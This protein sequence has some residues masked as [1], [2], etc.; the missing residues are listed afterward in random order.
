M[1]AVMRRSESRIFLYRR[2][3]LPEEETTAPGLQKPAFREP[4]LSG[5][6]GPDIAQ[7]MYGRRPKNS[8]Y[9]LQGYVSRV[10]HRL[11]A[12]FAHLVEHL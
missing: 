5:Q 12:V 8:K 3:G 11:G 6:P 7:A 10:D 9:R 1:G 4:H 2:R